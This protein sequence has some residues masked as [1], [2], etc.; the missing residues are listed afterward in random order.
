MEHKTVFAFSWF[1][2]LLLFKD[3]PAG[4]VCIVH[5]FK[6]AILASRFTDTCLHKSRLS[7]FHHSKMYS[8]IG[9]DDEFFFSV[10]HTL[11]SHIFFFF[12]AYKLEFRRQILNERRLSGS[13]K[14]M[15][16]AG[17]CRMEGVGLPISII[18]KWR[19]KKSW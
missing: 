15:L 8:L 10:F 6:E 17:N 2:S 14:K 9:F 3:T 1:F 13:W 5:D 19:A 12:L 11:L 7:R 16:L 4:N 18:E